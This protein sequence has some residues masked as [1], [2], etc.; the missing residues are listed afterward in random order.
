MITTQSARSFRAE[1]GFLR[2]RLTGEIITDPDLADDTLFDPYDWRALADKIEW[3]LD[4]KRA[5]YAKQRKFYDD[6]LSKR[7]WDD[8]VQE[9]LAILDAIAE[10]A[11]P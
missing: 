4:N 5:L 11:A 9:H 1:R 8:V 3:A 6:V 7:T 2:A 10:P